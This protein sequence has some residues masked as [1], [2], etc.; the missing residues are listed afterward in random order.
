MNWFL[1]W[2][3]SVPGWTKFWWSRRGDF[4]GTAWSSSRWWTRRRGWCPAGEV[5]CARASWLILPG[6]TWPDTKTSPMTWTRL[7]PKENCQTSTPSWQAPV[8]RRLS[9]SEP[10][11]SA[12]TTWATEAWTTRTREADLGRPWLRGGRCRGR[13]R[14]ARRRRLR[15]RAGGRLCEVSTSLL[16]NLNLMR[17]YCSSPS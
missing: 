10:V 1:H 14:R 6:P 17:C 4:R 7:Y 15:R 11:R 16:L 8:R 9:T 13:W 3:V 5:P 2:P 12:S